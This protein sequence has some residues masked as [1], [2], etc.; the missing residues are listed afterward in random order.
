MKLENLTCRICGSV[1]K[2]LID[3][4][5][6]PPANFL[7]ETAHSQC[8]TF[9]LEVEFCGECK[10]LQLGFCLDN[11]LLY[12]EYV[13]E[14]PK[15]ESLSRHYNEIIHYLIRGSYIHTGSSVLEVGSN[16]GYFLNHLKPHVDNVQ[17]VEPA[18]RIAKKANKLGIDTINDFFS[19]NFVEEYLTKNSNPTAIF[20]RHCFAHNKD[21][22]ELLG[23]SRRLLSD[24]GFLFVENAYALDTIRKNEFDQIYHEH[25]YYFSV[26]AMSAALQLNGLRLVDVVRSDVHGG[27]IMFIACHEKASSLALPTVSELMEVEKNVLTENAVTALANHAYSYRSVLQHLLHLIKSA[28]MTIY[29]YGATAK[30]STLLNFLKLDPGTIKFCIDNT[31]VKQHKFMPGTAI[32]IVPEKILE[33]NPPDYILLTAWNYCEELVAKIKK[34]KSSSSF[35]ILPFPNLVIKKIDEM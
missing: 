35:L 2:T 10:N 22:H 1:T 5:Q 17:G 14:T 29:A 33:E 32:E 26:T 34:T 20:A 15:S 7:G 21:I 9:P 4:G 16:L 28:D 12:G 19:K 27:S 13:Y 11:E 6:M 30:A 31:P 24:D 23:A 18:K 25:M 8:K 3:L